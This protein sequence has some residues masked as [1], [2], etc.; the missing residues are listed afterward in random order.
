MAL[1]MVGCEGYLSSPTSVVT[2]PLN[3]TH[4]LCHSPY[5]THERERERG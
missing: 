4:W 1:V 5:S 3:E 2:A